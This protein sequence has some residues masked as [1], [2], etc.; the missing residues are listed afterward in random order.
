MATEPDSAEQA[1]VSWRRSRAC[2]GVTTRLILLYVER[3]AGRAGV[4]KLLRLSGLADREQELRDEGS[5]FTFEEKIGLLSGAVEVTGDE[6]APERVGESALEF[7]IALA[8]KRALRALGSP[9]F[10]YRNRS[11]ERR[12]G[13]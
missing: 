8:L 2:S 9:D 7:S 6:R 10:V 3:E 12:V 4:E 1:K 11:E 5:W 13:K